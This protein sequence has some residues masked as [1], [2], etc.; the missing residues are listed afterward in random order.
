MSPSGPPQ[1]RYRDAQLEESK[2]N[3]PP[4]WRNKDAA[5]IFMAKPHG[6]GGPPLDSPGG[7][8]SF[9]S[10]LGSKGFVKERVAG[11]TSTR[12]HGSRVRSNGRRR[13]VNRK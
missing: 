3:Q 7:P 11:D 8:A 10:R 12:R 4:G 5:P 9:H 6:A 1:W 13:S 2:R